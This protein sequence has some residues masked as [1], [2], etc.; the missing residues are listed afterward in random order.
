M[1]QSTG[2]TGRGVTFE[3]SDGQSP[4]GFTAIAN[5][6]SMQF[7]GRDAQEID[8]TLLSS[9][10]GFR[11]LRQGFKD[12]GQIT[13]DL[14][15]DPTN[16]TFQDLL[17]KFLSGASFEFRINYVGAGWQM[18]QYGTGFVK[19]PGDEAINPNDPVGGNA[20]VRV[21]GPTEYRNT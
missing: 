20:V 7:T 12:P 19:N 10:G 15:S 17:A 1:T 13:L 18:Y 2:K 5:L 14:H 16:I 9:S 4:A 6:K 11:D 3:I 21:S 8:F